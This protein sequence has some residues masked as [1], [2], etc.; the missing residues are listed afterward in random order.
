MNVIQECGNKHQFKGRVYMNDSYSHGAFPT[1]IVG[2]L[3]LRE[4]NWYYC[5]KL[6]Y[7]GLIQIGWATSGFTPRSSEGLGV[8]DDEY[9][10]SFDGSRGVLF[11]KRK[12][13]LLP[14]HIRMQP[15]DVCGCGIGINGQNT[16]IKYW[17]NG[18]YLG[19]TF[20]HQSDIASTTVKC[21]LLPNGSNTTYFPSVSMNA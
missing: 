11:S 4:G 10:W 21:N 16:R 20:E 14:G 6:P 7:A 15:N 5:V 1:F 18:K 19:T 8:G 13:Y 17:L 9:S 2:N 3:Q 12:S